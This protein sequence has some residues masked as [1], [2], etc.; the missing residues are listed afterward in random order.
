MFR[1]KKDAKEKEP[2]CLQESI[3]LSSTYGSAGQSCNQDL[4]ENPFGENYQEDVHFFKEVT[5][6][7]EVFVRLERPVPWLFLYISRTILKTQPS[8][9]ESFWNC[10]VYNLGAA[11]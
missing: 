6:L 1:K 10:D 5:I 4:R 3:D 9:S 2:I 7:V 8:E 11:I